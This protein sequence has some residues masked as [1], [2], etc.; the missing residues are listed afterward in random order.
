[1]SIKKVALILVAA[2]LIWAGYFVYYISAPV[3]REAGEIIVE[4]PKGSSFRT[5]NEILVE[6][7]LVKHPTLFHLLAVITRATRNLQAGEYEFDRLMTPRGILGKMVRGEYRFFLVTIPE[8]FT[9]REI[10]RL[11]ASFGLVKEDVFLSLV[12]DG[13]FVKSLGINGPA[14]EGF[15]FPDTYKLD[16]TMGASEIIRIM[17]NRFWKSVSPKML[18][19]AERLGFSAVEWVTLAS[20]IG[21]ESGYSTEKPLVAAVFHNR[22]KKGMKLQSDPT[23]V[24]NVAGFSGKIKRRHLK[25]NTPHNTYLIEALPPTPIGN[26]GLD[27]LV[28]ALFP[29]PVDYLYFVSKRDGTHHFS[30]NLRDHNKA[31]FKYQ[32]NKKQ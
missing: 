28:A 3:G 25:N 11:L 4:I 23:A 19:Q 14:A 27:S 8:D 29:A 18:A 32:I 6:A 7:S 31:V 10:A 21:K 13:K 12:N 20:I 24:Y 15:L 16:R 9:A 30:A 1:M 22:L 2:S 26:P 17:V 5:A